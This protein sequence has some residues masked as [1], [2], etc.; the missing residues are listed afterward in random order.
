VTDFE[1]TD[2]FRGTGLVADPYEYFDWL[3]A[4]LPVHQDT[5]HDVMLVTGYDE[6]AAIHADHVDVLFV[7]LPAPS[8]RMD[9]DTLD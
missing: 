3:R 9:P 7:Q 2:F 1:A 8:P 5:H 4:Q 6:A